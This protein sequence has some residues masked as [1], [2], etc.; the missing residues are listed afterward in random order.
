MKTI[1]LS[2]RCNFDSSELKK[3]VKLAGCKHAQELTSKYNLI[4]DEE[5]DCYYIHICQVPFSEMLR[6]NLVDTLDSLCKNIN[7]YYF[8]YIHEFPND[9]ILYE[10]FDFDKLDVDDDLQTFENSL[11]V[12]EKFS[13]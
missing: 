11:V 10:H 3:I 7:L 1:Y 4:F 8:R 5:C 12:F 2:L 9:P 13:S 6:G